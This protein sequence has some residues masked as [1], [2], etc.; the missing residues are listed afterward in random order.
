MNVSSG[1]VSSGV[2]LTNEYMFVESGIAQKCALNC[3]ECGKC[4]AVLKQV[5]GQRTENLPA[6]SFSFKPLSIS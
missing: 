5:V 4:D 6:Y 1:E 3:T 2:T